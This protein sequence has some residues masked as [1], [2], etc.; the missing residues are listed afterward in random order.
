MV[1]LTLLNNVNAFL[2][3][4]EHTQTQAYNL[5]FSLLKANGVMN[6]TEKEIEKWLKKERPNQKAESVSTEDEV[7]TE[8]KKEK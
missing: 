1:N 8:T 3:G 2:K 5:Y 6:M 4:K 7:P